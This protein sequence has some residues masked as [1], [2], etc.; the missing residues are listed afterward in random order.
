[1]TVEELAKKLGKSPQRIRVLI[2]HEKLKAGD[3]LVGVCFKDEGHQRY[4]Y[5]IFPEV[6][7]LLV[8]E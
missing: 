4:D 7:K 2:Q 8:G 3:K 6:A 5:T 1:M